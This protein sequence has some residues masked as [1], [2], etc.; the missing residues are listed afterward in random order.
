MSAAAWV[1]LGEQ[2]NVNGAS[3]PVSSCADRLNPLPPCDF[4]EAHRQ[5]F[6]RLRILHPKLKPEAIAE[7][8][9]GARAGQSPSWL[10]VGFWSKEIDLVLL[11]GTQGGQVDRA[12]AIDRI[13]R[14][15]P[16]IEAQ[17]L[18]ERMEELALD[19]LPAYLQDRFWTAEMDGLLDAGLK[20]GRPGQQAAINKIL[21]MHPELRIPLVRKRLRQLA[22]RVPRDHTRRGR[23]YPWTPEL[24]AQLAAASTSELAAGVT[25]IQHA[26][27]WPRQIIYRRAHRLGI[28]SGEHHEQRWT[29]SDRKYVVEHVNHQAVESIAKALGRSVKS[30]R[31]KIEEMGLSGR[32][33]EDYSIKRLATELHVRPST[34]RTWINR[35]WLKRGRRGRIKER[36]LIIFLR[37]H[38]REL[39]WNDLEP[40]IQAF[41]LECVQTEGEEEAPQEAASAVGIA[42]D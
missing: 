3:R 33:E 24:D 7:R 2:S 30:V 25:R 20:D 9:R 40:H 8:L 18:S 32:Y 27:G 10:T 13:R 38:W 19:G 34:V 41:I 14:V 36:E 22:R 35:G 42:A 1:R 4:A 31:R 23:P 17:A 28:P 37:K 21:R 12:A 39:R 11:S 16:R 29:A 5:A 15:W 6:E 26:T